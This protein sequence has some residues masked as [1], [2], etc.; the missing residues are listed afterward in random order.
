LTNERIS[1]GQSLELEVP[2]EKIPIFVMNDLLLPLATPT[3][4]IDDPVA[5]DLTIR[6]YGNGQWG[7]TLYEDDGMSFDFERKGCPE[8]YLFWN[9]ASKNICE[10][11]SGSKS[12][13]SYNILNWNL[14]A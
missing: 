6:V 12:D 8:H 1:G 10:K 5:R 7:I 2:L 9:D 11:F 4:N 14:Y 13:M 3:L